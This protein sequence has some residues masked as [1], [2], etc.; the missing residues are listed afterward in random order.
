M[1]LLAGGLFVWRYGDRQAKHLSMPTAQGMAPAA[2][3]ALSAGATVPGA[4]SLSPTSQPDATTMPGKRG[5][6]DGT[7]V[8]SHRLDAGDTHRTA[9]T[10]TNLA[11]RSVTATKAQPVLPRAPS[12][13]SPTLDMLLADVQ[14]GDQERRDLAL[15]QIKQLEPAVAVPALKALAEKTEDLQA[16]IAILQAMQ[17]LELPSYVPKKKNGAT[18]PKPRE[19]RGLAR[20]HPGPAVSPQPSPVAEKPPAQGE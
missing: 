6:N 4:V 12:N 15:E 13:D 1:V 18:S 9:D 17:F 11:V 7:L 14:T 16:K 10:L 3:H 20:R 2:T 19:Q 8:A 5:T